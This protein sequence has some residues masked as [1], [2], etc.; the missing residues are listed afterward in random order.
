MNIVSVIRVSI[1]LGDIPLNA[2]RVTKDDGT[3]I[4][5]LPGKSVSNVIGEH[6]STLPRSMGVKSLKDL[7]NKDSSLPPRIKA[8]AG[9]SFTPIAVK[10]AVIYWGKM[11][12]RKN[13]KAIAIL[14]ASAIESIERRIDAVIQAEKQPQESLNIKEEIDALNVSFDGNMKEWEGSRDYSAS[15]HPWFQEHCIFHHYPAAKVHDMITMFVFGQTAE[16]ARQKQIV[17]EGMDESI[18]LNHQES[19]E[20]QEVIARVKRKFCLLKKGTWRE[21]VERACKEAQKLG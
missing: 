18:G 5:L 2:Y 6:D 21:K 3:H 14:V 19:K 9:E 8:D 4:D 11:A 10:D 7:P 13:Q 12:E 17:I 20:G 1:N 15:M 16:M